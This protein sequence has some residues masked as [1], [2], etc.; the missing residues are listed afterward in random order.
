VSRTYC[1]YILAS[2]SR[3]LYTG[4]TNDLERR[5]SEHRQELVLGF[6]SRY[7]IFRL[8]HCEPFGD[9]RAAIAREK[10][11]KAW[12]RE[13]RVRLIERDNPLWL[14]LSEVP[15]PAHGP[16]QKTKKEKADPSRRSPGGGRTGSE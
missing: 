1:V 5:L 11:I 14:D 8:V 7:R 4:V 12:R 15:F 9:I 13:K 3:N 16:A 10:E 6:T 2:R